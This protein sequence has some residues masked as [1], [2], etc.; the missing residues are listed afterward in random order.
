MDSVINSI[1]VNSTKTALDEF[2]EQKVD[3]DI[4]L[5]DYCPAAKRILKCDVSAGI[6]SKTADN[7]KL[8][9]DIQ[10]KA[11]VVYVDDN[12]GLVHSVTKTETFNK[13]LSLK[14]PLS[15]S[16]I[17]TAV[18]ASSVNCRLQ[19][20]RRISVKSVV[21]TA[22]KI[23]GNSE[24]QIIG[25]AYGGGIES[26]F[27][28]AEANILCG[29]GETPIQTNG[30]LMLDAGITEIISSDA[31]LYI[32]DA[33]VITDKVI[34]KGEAA[35]SIVYMTG[36][37]VK[38]FK[39][40]E[41]TVPFSEVVDVYG[42]TENALCDVQWELYD[43]RCELSDDNGGVTC[44]I[45]ASVSASVYNSSQ[46]KMLKDVYSMTDNLNVTKSNLLIESFNKTITLN[47]NINGSIPC[48]FP[49]ARIIGVCAN[50]FVKNIA[51]RD[52]C[53]QIDGEMNV[54]VYMCNEDDYGVVE[55]SIPFSISR[56]AGECCDNMRCEASLDIK[57]LSYSM[58][59]DDTITINAEAEITLNC[60]VRDTYTAIDT[61]EIS[62]SEQPMC[63]GVVLYYAEQG[64]ALWDIAKKYRSSVDIIKRDNKIDCDK[65]TEDKMLVISFN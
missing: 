28:S 17:R 15:V 65:L 22:V 30:Q 38:D 25:E 12:S 5:P 54:S 45:D 58:P 10:C 39:F 24:C 11:R 27:N 26:D 29:V 53:F 47:E 55:K 49:E 52:D 50:A 4:V 9:L 2:F 1:G 20:S 63:K 13:S 36:E 33:K 8:T 46:I 60:F 21:G 31:T 48:E 42:A 7:E 19:N 6:I 37:S 64:E 18:R 35:V 32:T 59:N 62:D 34:V 41:G 40:Y 56:Q 51:L 3:F 43:V 44:E 14:I 61:I 16:K 57:N 23:I